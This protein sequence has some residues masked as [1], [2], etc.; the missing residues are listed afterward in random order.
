MKTNFKMYFFK[1]TF[2]KHVTEEC[3]FCWKVLLPTLSKNM[4]ATMTEF[5][6]LFVTVTINIDLQ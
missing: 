2:L 4:V 5:L 1:P 6:L 3:T